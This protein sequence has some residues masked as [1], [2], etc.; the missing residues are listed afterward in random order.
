MLT[1]FLPVLTSPMRAWYVHSPVSGST[2]MFILELSYIANDWLVL[3]E[4]VQ[5]HDQCSRFLLLVA[6]SRVRTCKHFAASIKLQCGQRCGLLEPSFLHNAWSLVKPTTPNA[7]DVPGFASCPNGSVETTQRFDEPSRRSSIYS[8]EHHVAQ[9]GAGLP[10]K[11]VCEKSLLSQTR[12]SVKLVDPL[13]VMLGPLDVKERDNPYW[14][15]LPRYS[16]TEDSYI[17]ATEN[18]LAQDMK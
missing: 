12:C 13:G 18:V 10:R 14:L 16:L 3:R 7:W 2:C 5:P 1:L 4:V 15:T 9:L 11:S 6:V 17:Q 8:R